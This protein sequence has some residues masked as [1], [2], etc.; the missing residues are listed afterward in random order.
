MRELEGNC[1]SADWELY[2]LAEGLRYL[3]KKKVYLYV[4][5]NLAW[6]CYV[7]HLLHDICQ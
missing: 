6:C 7:I 1:N 5:C 3:K 2:F 4:K